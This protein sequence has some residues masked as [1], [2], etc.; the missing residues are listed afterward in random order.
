MGTRVLLVSCYELGRQPLHVATAAAFLRAAG[1]D[2]RA[3]DLA[4]DDFDAS[5]VEWSETVALAV[6]MHT[7]MRLAAGV[8]Q[9]VR[10]LH[11][12]ATIV[13]YGLYAPLCAASL[14][15]GAADHAVGGEFEE[16]LVRIADGRP[17]GRGLVL[18][19]LRFPVPARDLL[20][21]SLIHI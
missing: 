6:P 5:L 12:A 3:L 15:P 16:E 19:R 7:A 8:A 1:H 4:V 14:P 11:P 18:D 9:R 20:P 17:S 13:L 10:G 2:V 21:L